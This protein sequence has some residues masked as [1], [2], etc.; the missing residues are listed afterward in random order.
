M[1]NLLWNAL[2]RVYS[3]LMQYR[4]EILRSLRD[5]PPVHSVLKIQSLSLFLNTTR[6]KVMTPGH[7]NLIELHSMDWSLWKSQFFRWKR[8]DS[9]GEEISVLGNPIKRQLKDIQWI[10]KSRGSM[11]LLAWKGISL[12]LYS[13]DSTHTFKF[14]RIESRER[15]RGAHVFKHYAS[16]AMKILKQ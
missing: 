7:S 9:R 10:E 5:V 8:W 15:E 16:A 12:K 11:Q 14:V 2:F 1:F 4:A 3:L 13:M 6:I